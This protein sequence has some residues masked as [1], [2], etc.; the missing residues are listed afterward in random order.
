MQH[1]HRDYVAEGE[2]AALSRGYV[3]MNDHPLGG[4]QMHSPLT[5]AGVSTPGSPSSP[6]G[7]DPL[8]SGMFHDS[9]TGP[10]AS[11]G[12]SALSRGDPFQ[13]GE[14]TPTSSAKPKGEMALPARGYPGSV[15]RSS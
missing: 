15:S 14:N 5:P 6:F 10:T 13:S 3:R 11:V 12:A 4:A 2:A 1:R 7:A 9:L 8:S